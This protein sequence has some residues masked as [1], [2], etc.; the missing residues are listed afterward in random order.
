MDMPNREPSNEPKNRANHEGNHEQ[1]APHVCHLSHGAHHKSY[2][3]QIGPRDPTKDPTKDPTRIPTRDVQ[4]ISQRIDKGLETIRGN[5]ESSHN[6][7]IISKL[8]VIL[9][10]Q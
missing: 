2:W 4:G 7:N 9:A 10:I 1:R 3:S 5:L 8:Y 6:F